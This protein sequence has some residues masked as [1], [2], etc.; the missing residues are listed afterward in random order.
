M[1]DRAVVLFAHGARDPRWAEPLEALRR[2]L[3]Q[4]GCRVAVAFLELMTPTLAEVVAALAA[5]GDRA[6]EIVPVFLGQGGH[7]R[8]DLPRLVDDVRSRHPQVD[9]R[10]AHAVGEDDGVLDA[11]ADYC[12]R[13]AAR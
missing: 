4:R 9:L 10:L 5:G 2:R 13:S 11:I 8:E 12:V 7:V 1:A 3:E 6:I